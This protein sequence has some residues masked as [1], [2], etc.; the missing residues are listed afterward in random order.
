M[1]GAFP[2]AVANKKGRFE[3]ADRGTLFLDEIGQMSLNIQSKLLR[4]L[5]DGTFDPVGSVENRSVD[6]RVITATNRSLQ[7]EIKEGRFLSDLFYRIEVISINVPPLR[8]RTDDI[9]LLANHFIRQYADQYGKTI[10]S[11]HPLAVDLLINHHWPGNV[12][13]LENCLARAVILCKG[14]QIGISDLPEKIKGSA[15][16]FPSRQQESLIRNI[17][18]Q[19]IKLKALERELILKTL[20]KC[21]GNKTLTAN[22]LGISR[23]GLYEKMERYEIRS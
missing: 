4:F 7:E 6:V 3:L 15:E 11:I 17:P 22:F 13:E 16:N 19:G 12:R 23:K 5:Q 14:H 18:E 21:Q 8:E 9:V 1:N 10:D 2:G 20:E